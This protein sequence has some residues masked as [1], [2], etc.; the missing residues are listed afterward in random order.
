MGFKEDLIADWTD[1]TIEYQGKRI[2]ILE[3]FDYKG[4]NYL[5]GCDIDTINNKDLE[6][7]FLTKVKDNIFEH[8]EDDKLFDE[9]FEIVAG[10]MLSDKLDEI[11]KKYSN[12]L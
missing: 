1:K 9:L 3:Q 5:Y 12:V 6:V 8:V 4:K 2:Y 10:K 7:V 11:Y